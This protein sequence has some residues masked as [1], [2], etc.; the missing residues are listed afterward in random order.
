[1]SRMTW[2]EQFLHPSEEYTPIPFWF[3]ND[4]LTEE[5]P[6]RQIHDFAEKGVMGFVIHPRI[7]I[8]ES[9]P[10]LSDTYMNLVRFAVKEAASLGMKVILYD[11]AMYPS[12]AAKGLVVQGNPEYASRGL[13]MVEKSGAERLV[14]SDALGEGDVLVSVQAV[15]KSTEGSI[16]PADSV[17]LYPVE[18]TVSLERTGGGSA[19]MDDS[20]IYRDVLQRNDPRDPLRGG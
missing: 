2:E 20:P 4:N 10:Y 12:G 13:K 14:L 1:M 16:D 17:L 9:I 18:D 3:W 7:G 6:R 19:G 15:K 8:P 11:E 5:E